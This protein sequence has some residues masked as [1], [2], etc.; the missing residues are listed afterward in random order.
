MMAR[1]A[2][3]VSVF[4]VIAAFVVRTSWWSRFAAPRPVGP[5]PM[6]NTSTELGERTSALIEASLVV[7]TPTY[8]IWSCLFNE[9]QHLRLN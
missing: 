4:A 5:A 9:P 2:T 1:P 3:S 8:L 7:A 6:I